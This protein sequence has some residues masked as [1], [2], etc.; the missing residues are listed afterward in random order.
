MALL[1]ATRTRALRVPTIQLAGVVIAIAAMAGGLDRPGAATDASAA[2]PPRAH[3][4]GEHLGLPGGNKV[5]ADA[6]LGPADG[7]VPDGATAFDTNL[8]A[9]ANLAPDLLGALQRAATDAAADDVRITIDSGWRSSE[10]QAQLLR[11]AV[12]TYGS[13]EEAARWV[14][15]PATS[16]HVSGEAVDVGPAAATQWLKEHGANY[17]L[18]Q[19]YRN[20]AWHYELRPA[21]A[22]SGCPRMYEDAARDPRSQP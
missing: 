14:A 3:A 12:S 15:T 1:D 8:P 16:A 11:E 10:Y 4:A 5:G 6:P 21:A 13:A 19:I 22:S 18:C 9:I 7:A 2:E 20:E 17:G